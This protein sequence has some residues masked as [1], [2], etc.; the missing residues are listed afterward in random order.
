VRSNGVDI[1]GDLVH[2]FTVK[3]GQ[4]TAFDQVLAGVAG[5]T[6]IRGQTLL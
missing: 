3:D 2:I 6:R 4:I 1:A 5:L